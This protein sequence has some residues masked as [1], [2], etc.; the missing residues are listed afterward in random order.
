MAYRRK[1]KPV[2]FSSL[3]A[4]AGLALFGGG[5]GPAHAGDYVFTTLPTFIQPN[6]INDAG[7]IVGLS[8]SPA[9]GFQ[10]LL[11]SGGTYTPFNDPSAGTGPN[12][13]T[14]PIAINNLGQIVGNYIDSSGVVHALRG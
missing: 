3:V 6:G 4:I 11:Y 8:G 7:Q 10:G 9:A 5:A 14:D 13:F 2:K 12:Q 1:A